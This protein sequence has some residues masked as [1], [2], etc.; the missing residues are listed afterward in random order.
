[1]PLCT[2]IQALNSQFCTC[3]ACTECNI[4]VCHIAHV[5]LVV[6]CCRSCESGISCQKQMCSVCTDCFTSTVWASIK[7]SVRSLCM[8]LNGASFC[9]LYGRPSFS[10]GRMPY[11]CLLA[12]LSWSLNLQWY[13]AVCI[14]VNTVRHSLQKGKGP[15]GTDAVGCFSCELTSVRSSCMPTC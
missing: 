9:R 3:D 8:P 12:H 7:W 5:R 13:S 15:F 10:C 2:A 6:F 4:H 11:R 14:A 1:M